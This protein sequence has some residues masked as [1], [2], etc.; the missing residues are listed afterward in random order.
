MFETYILPVLIF[1]GIGI[2]AGALLTVASKIFAVKTDERT[3]AISEVLPQINCG[4]CGYSGCADYT[5][6]VLAG[7]PTNLCKAGGTQT[8]LR[9]SALM[10]VEA[11]EV[12]TQIAVV[13]C[14]GDCHATSSKYVFE[15]TQSCLAAN[16]FYNGSENCTHGCLGFGDCAVVCPSDAIVIENNLA[17]VNKS[18]CIGCGL[19]VKACPNTLI[20]L[21]G[22]KSYVD[23]LCCSTDMGKVTKSICKTGCIGC[24]LCEKKCAFNAI[25]VENN[26]AKIDYALCTSCGECAKV[27][28]TR[29]ILDCR[30][31]KTEAAS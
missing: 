23:V 9:L 11:G 16:R 12:D 28:P 25:K 14:G 21:H 15:G 17:R 31:K 26:L 3:E 27:C 8:A 30:A 24:K 18:K 10:G 6:A 22:I 1:A 19:C 2:L 7:A 13:H 4:A 5:A 29:A 20:S